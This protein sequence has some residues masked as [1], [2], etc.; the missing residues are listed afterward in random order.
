MKSI[1]HPSTGFAVWILVFLLIRCSIIV[2]LYL[3]TGGNEVAS[4]VSY[5]RMLLDRPFAIINGTAQHA[6]ASYAPLQSFLT[7][8]IYNIYIEVFPDFIAI[9]LLMVTFELLGF[10]LLFMILNRMTT[11]SEVGATIPKYLFF[12]IVVFAP[13]QFL[14]S[15]VFVQD[16]IICSLFLL[17]CLWFKLNKQH[18]LALFSLAAGKK[19]MWCE[20]NN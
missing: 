19:L 2:A 10:I 9:R 14:A 20:D 5:H 1:N 4:D 12:L 3:F 8:P 15:T 13:H 16:E 11:N 17:L 6:V 7:W 18:L